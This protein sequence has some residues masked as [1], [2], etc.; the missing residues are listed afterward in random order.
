MARNACLLV[1]GG[2]ANIGQQDYPSIMKSRPAPGGGVYWEWLH[3]IYPEMETNFSLS[4][5]LHL[6]K[7][8]SGAGAGMLYHRG[9]DNR[10]DDVTLHW[11]I[12]ADSAPPNGGSVQFGGPTLIERI[13]ADM[14]ASA[15]L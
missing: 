11:K 10:L 6:E 2:V 4:C 5:H 9:T 8:L 3:P 15:R 14:V 1:E 7:R 13:Q 12:F